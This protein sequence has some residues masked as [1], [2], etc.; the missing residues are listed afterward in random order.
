M[1]L[2]ETL[3]TYVKKAI[4]CSGTLGRQVIRLIPSRGM[5]G[6]KP[7]VSAIGLIDCPDYQFQ[8]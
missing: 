3:L 6:Y 5:S 4:I 7:E 8:C 1:V 2:A